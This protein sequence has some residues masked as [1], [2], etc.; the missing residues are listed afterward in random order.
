MLK[1]RQP[2]RSFS[3]GST[4]DVDLI[5]RAGLQERGYYYC[6]FITKDG[7][8]TYGLGTTTVFAT[9]SAMGRPCSIWIQKIDGYLFP[10]GIDFVTANRPLTYQPRDLR[11]NIYSVTFGPV[12][13]TNFVRQAY[14]SQTIQKLPTDTVNNWSFKPTSDESGSPSFFGADPFPGWSKACVVIYRVA[15][16]IGQTNGFINGPNDPAPWDPQYKNIAPLHTNQYPVFKDITGFRIAT[17][18]G[19]D[20]MTFNLLTEQL[21]QTLTLPSPCPSLFVAAAVWST[22]D[23]TT[24][25]TN[26]VKQA[27]TNADVTVSVTNNGMGQGF[28]PAD[29]WYGVKKQCTVLVGYPQTPGN[30][31]TIRWRT[32]VSS[33]VYDGWTFTIPRRLP[34]TPPTQSP[35]GFVSDDK[36][37]PVITEVFLTNLASSDAWPQVV[38][39]AGQ[40]VWDGKRVGNGNQ[41]KISKGKRNRKSTPDHSSPSSTQHH[42]SPPT[43]RDSSSAWMNFR[44]ES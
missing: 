41:W 21:N 3:Q 10:C 27:A 32:I 33:G 16:C 26:V 43:L 44:P 18:H 6:G 23:V 22:R 38:T 9:S 24:Y 36:T 4:K 39:D 42:S 20:T 14:I 29:P 17:A 5:G 19:G 7:S 2:F 13:Y 15:Y 35:T 34:A 31:S 28:N 25:V 37:K 40:V 11:L 12:E 8:Q 30:G 1:V